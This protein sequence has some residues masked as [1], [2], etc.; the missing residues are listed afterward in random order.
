MKKLSLKN[1]DML[2]RKEL[3]TIMGGYGG[4]PDGTAPCTCNGTSYG[5]QTV[6]SCWNKC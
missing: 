6:S 2:S 4:C 5:C 1:A 3:K